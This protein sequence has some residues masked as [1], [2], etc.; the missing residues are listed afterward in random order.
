MGMMPTWDPLD[1]RRLLWA[2][3]KVLDCQPPKA[4]WTSPSWV[5]MQVLESRA[6]TELPG[7]LAVLFTMPREAG[8]SYFYEM[9]NQLES[10]GPPGPLEPPEGLGPPGSPTQPRS[11]L[12]HTPIE[13][14]EVGATIWVWLEREEGGEGFVIP[15]SRTMGGGS[16]PM[17]SRWLDDTA[18]SRAAIDRVAPLRKP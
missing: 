12:D 15:T 18:A 17:H 3:V 10:G 2:K 13:L 11:Q 7:E 8:Q 9:R 1:D 16:V 14:P 6:P 4:T 5:R